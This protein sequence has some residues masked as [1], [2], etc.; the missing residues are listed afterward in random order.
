MTSSLLQGVLKIPP[1]AQAQVHRC[2]C[3]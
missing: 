1:P 3:H 2:W